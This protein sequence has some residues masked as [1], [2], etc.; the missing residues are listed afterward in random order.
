MGLNGNIYLLGWFIYFLILGCITC[1]LFI[2]ILLAI[3]VV[4]NAATMIPMYFLYMLSTFGFTLCMSLFF[5]NPRSGL[6]MITFLELILSNL[7]WLSFWTDFKNSKIGFIVVSIFPNAA[8][9]FG[10]FA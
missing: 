8:I 1:F 6:I 3:G 9:S 2:G 7:Y 4:N 10:I 5:E